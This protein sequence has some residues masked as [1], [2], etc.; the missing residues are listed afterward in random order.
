MKRFPKDFLWGTAISSYQTEGNTKNSDW[1]Q[2]EKQHPPTDNS[3]CGL[4]CDFWNKFEIYIAQAAALGSRALRLSLEWSR[5]Q[6][7]PEKFDK[8]ALS[9]Y[10]KIIQTIR[11]YKME[12]IVTVW[13]FSLPQWFADRGGWTKT[14]NRAYW[15]AYCQ[16]AQTALAKD[17]RYWITLN[18]PSAYAAQGYLIGGWPPGRH[19][20]WDF[21]A[22]RRNLIR[23]HHNAYA[24]LKKPDNLVGVSL[25]L[26]YDEIVHPD[27]FFEKI[28][29]AA[30]THYSDWGFLPYVRRALDFIG[31]NYYFHNKI[32]WRF[33]E[34]RK[35]HL[36]KSDIGWNV[37][38]KG[39]SWVAAR[40][41]RL[42]PKPIL[43]T[44]NGLA[45]S[46]DDLRP[47][48]IRDH[49]AWLNQAFNQGLPIIGYLHWSLMDNVEWQRGKQPR[50]GLMAMDYEH[51]TATPRPSFY[52]YQD[53]IKAYTDRL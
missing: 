44:E 16:T 14:R 4:A 23:A 53:I 51:L 5:I 41:Y 35:K 37:C 48:F 11:R 6:P 10:Q 34:G 19:S 36:D 28:I 52:A 22:V 42:C 12:P 49:I 24:I 43:I 25:N 40:A 46:H 50:F 7:T 18:E 21:L 29:L 38:P 47:A 3:R 30:L 9:Q 39:L 33:W 8:A 20:L 1:W 45:D 2:W 13:H 31:I 17:V 26:S 15:N 27:S 32:S